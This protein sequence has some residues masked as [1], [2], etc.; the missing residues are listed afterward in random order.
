MA[1][2]IAKHELAL[3]RRRMSADGN[4]EEAGAHPADRYM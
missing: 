2:W 1:D 3:E 4:N